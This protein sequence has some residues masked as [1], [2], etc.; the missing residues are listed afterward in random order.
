[1]DNVTWKEVLNWLEEQTGLAV[2]SNNTPLGR[3]TFLGPKGAR[4]TMPQILDILSEALRQQEM[5][6][7]RRERNFAL[8]FADQFVP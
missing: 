4:Y 7:I 5:L 3:F 1:M 8:V 6:L 2:V